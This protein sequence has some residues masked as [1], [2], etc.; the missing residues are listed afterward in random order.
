[1]NTRFLIVMQ[2][3]TGQPVCVKIAALIPDL[4]EA[5]QLDE[6]LLRQV[7]QTFLC[8]K[9]AAALDEVDGKAPRKS[10]VFTPLMMQAMKQAWIRSVQAGAEAPSQAK[11]DSN[12][13]SSNQ[14]EQ[15][16]EICYLEMLV[17]CFRCVFALIEICDRNCLT[18]TNNKQCSCCS[19]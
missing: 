10:H 16:G 8:T 7:F 1:M 6:G 5:N 18:V 15:S 19:F 17:P 9:L 11:K 3:E 4:Y 12:S 14:T 2:G 13:R